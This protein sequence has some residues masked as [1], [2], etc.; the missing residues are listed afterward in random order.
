MD[1]Y[2]AVPV[3]RS[4]KKDPVVKSTAPKG[5]SQTNGK[6]SQISGSRPISAPVEVPATPGAYGGIVER[7]VPI[8]EQTG[9]G[10]MD[11][12]S[13]ASSA[14]VAELQ[15]VPMEQVGA[16]SVAYGTKPTLHELADAS[17]TGPGLGT[18][19][20]KVKLGGYVDPDDSKDV[21]VEPAGLFGGGIPDLKTYETFVE[22]VTSF[23]DK[24]ASAQGVEPEGLHVVDDIFA[25][26][27][28]S[29]A[30]GVSNLGDFGA[31][32]FFE[33][34]RDTRSAREKHD[35][36][37]AARAAEE[38]RHQTVVDETHDRLDDEVRNRQEEMWQDA[39]RG[40]V[41]VWGNFSV[42][43]VTRA[44]ALRDIV[45]N[46]VQQRGDPLGI[47]GAA[48]A[49]LTEI[50]TRAIAEDE[51]F[52]P[53]GLFGPAASGGA[54]GG[55]TVDSIL[56]NILGPSGRPQEKKDFNILDVSF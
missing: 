49:E 44:D 18:D 39:S 30:K 20:V 4:P 8:V 16:I 32:L 13:Q 5:I 55:Q 15:G 51:D 6:G 34:L 1:F 22:P 52:L 12:E 24:Q 33:P 54:A 50:T 48:R 47:R 53:G 40:Q 11:Y 37:I 21:D 17:R 36:V 42:Q 19:I 2:D 9:T 43:P 28:V 10:F 7:A 46:P 56:A 26:A 3:K 23:I 27:I 29:T 25:D 31:D 45:G 41:D 38:E 35:E 14:N